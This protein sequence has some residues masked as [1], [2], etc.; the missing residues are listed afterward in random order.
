MTGD[1]L[2]LKMKGT[3]GK[4]N[5]FSFFL[6]WKPAQSRPRSGFKRHSFS[7]SLFFNCLLLIG[8]KVSN[9]MLIGSAAE[10]I[11]VTIIPA[12]L[13]GRENQK[14]KKKIAWCHRPISSF[15]LISTSFLARDSRK[16]LKQIKNWMRTDIIAKWALWTTDFAT[17]LLFS[18]WTTFP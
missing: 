10:K 1:S 13:S 18:S 7:S 6:E 3:R 2:H 11:T 17:E 9:S 12:M 8:T 16:N 5:F 15:L 14:K 4:F